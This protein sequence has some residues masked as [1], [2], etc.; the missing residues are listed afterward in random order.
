[1]KLDLHNHTTVN[2]LFIL[3]S[4]VIDP[5][6][7]WRGPTRCWEPGDWTSSLWFY[8]FYW[9]LNISSSSASKLNLKHFPP[10]WLR[11]YKPVEQLLTT[12]RVEVKLCF[13]VCQQFCVFRGE[14]I[15]PEDQQSPE[16]QI[17]STET[18]HHKPDSQPQTSRQ[19]RLKQTALQPP[20][21]QKGKKWFMFSDWC[22]LVS[23]GSDRIVC[24]V[25]TWISSQSHVSFVCSSSSADKF[26]LNVFQ[27]SHLNQFYL[28]MSTC[29]WNR[30]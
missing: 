12:N 1:M 18:P 5:T 26:S 15:D 4:P 23:E 11:C 27:V 13:L 30:K 2:F 9:S 19:Q 29:D 20:D 7:L 6:A 14:F 10:D 8:Y 28:R 22:G 24:S 21:Q 3:S 17:R 25:T 16:D